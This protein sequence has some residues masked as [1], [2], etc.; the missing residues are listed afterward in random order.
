MR[1]LLISD[2]GPV[3]LPDGDADGYADRLNRALPGK[4]FAVRGAEH[5]EILIPQGVKV[6]AIQ[7]GMWW[8]MTARHERKRNTREL[9]CL[10]V[11]AGAFPLLI[12]PA[13]GTGM[14]DIMDLADHLL[15]PGGDDLHPALYGEPVTHSV[16]LSLKRD[17]WDMMMVRAALAA[18]IEITAICRG[19][20]VVNA[21]LGG[22]VTQDVNL[23]GRTKES[24]AGTEHDVITEK[25]SR[26]EALLGRTVRDMVSRHHQEIAL[27]GRG[28]EVTGRSPDG[29]IEIMEGLG[30]M[31]YQFHPE[32][33]PES[34]QTQKIFEEVAR[35]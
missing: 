19:I 11:E 1:G 23:N 27:P 3:V 16:G 35:R 15:M 22:T 34:R 31:C 8:D 25:G 4:E 30:I 18:G 21:V 12:P 32:N 17:L 13:L 24:H 14:A 9:A 7:L 29:L 10:L 6:V 26:A 2:L 20:D 28:L 33:T 5:V